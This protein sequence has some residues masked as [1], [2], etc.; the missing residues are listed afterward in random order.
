MINKINRQ[1]ENINASLQ[2]IK[3]HKPEHYAQ[4]FPQL[5]QQR[6]Q[7]RRMAAAEEEFPAIAAYGESQRGKSYVMSNVLQKDGKPFTITA[8]GRKIN[9]IER[10]NPPTVNTEAT[11]VV[12]RFTS[13]LK[14]P[15]LYNAQYPVLMKVL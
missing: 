14:N 4:R 7:L 11:G 2:W 10:I 5:V 9:F 3:A 12:T 8:N 6:C 15:G 13:F 1:I